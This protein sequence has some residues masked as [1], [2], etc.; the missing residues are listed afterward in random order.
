MENKTIKQAVAQ[1]KKHQQKISKERDALRL[2]VEEIEGD[3]ESLDGALEDL[4]WA[5]DKLSERF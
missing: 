3:L 2:L 1:F 5:I 4:E